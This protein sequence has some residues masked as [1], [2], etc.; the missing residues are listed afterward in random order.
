MKIPFKCFPVVHISN[1][2]GGAFTCPSCGGIN[3]HHNEVTSY[4]RR[5]EGAAET[6]ETKIADGR[7]T[8]LT[9]PST[10]S[11]NPS[12]RRGAIVIGFWCETC[13]ARPELVLLQH[14]GSTYTYWQ[15]AQVAHLEIPEGGAQ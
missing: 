2:D 5:K 12:E 15:P 14:K 13:P 8:S 3:L 10:N 11:R 4:D 6:I 9:V 7:T 1:E